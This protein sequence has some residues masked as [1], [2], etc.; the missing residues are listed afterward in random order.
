MSNIARNREEWV[1]PLNDTVD[2]ILDV[3]FESN[4]TFATF[5][6]EDLEF[7]LGVD[8]V[9]E[10]TMVELKKYYPVCRVTDCV[11]ITHKET[12][13][14]IHVMIHTLDPNLAIRSGLHAL[15]KLVAQKKDPKANFA[16]RK[17]FTKTLKDRG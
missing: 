11:K 1:H 13:C 2:E 16:S 14:F 6:R 5:H 3:L 9:H 17:F 8:V 4:N 10:K 7:E 12:K 15:R